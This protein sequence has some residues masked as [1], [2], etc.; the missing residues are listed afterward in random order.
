M[1]SQKL[2]VPRRTMSI[3]LTVVVFLLAIFSLNRVALPKTQSK[4][5]PAASVPSPQNRTIILN[6]GY[7]QWITSPALIAVGAQ[8]NEWRVISDTINGAPQPPIANGRPSDV[9]SD[10]DWAFVNPSLDTNF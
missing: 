2:F 7:D 4:P 3:S 9:V 5:S 1:A 10:S 6:T 8:D